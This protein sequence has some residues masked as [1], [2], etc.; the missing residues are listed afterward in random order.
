MAITTALPGFNEL[1]SSVIP[2][3]LLMGHFLYR[4]STFREK[5]KKMYR[6]EV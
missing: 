5:M 3:F 6:L 4:L 1:G 2:V